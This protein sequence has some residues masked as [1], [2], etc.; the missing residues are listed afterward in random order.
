MGWAQMVKG[1]ANAANENL[2]GGLKAADAYYTQ[3][4]NGIN[5]G[6]QAAVLN[7]QAETMDYLSGQAMERA[8][9]A[10]EAGEQTA[11]RRARQASEDI[12]SA[13]AHAAGAGFLVGK[14]TA[15]SVEENIRAGAAEDIET[16]NRNT[17][18]D[19]WGHTQEAANLKAQGILTRGDAEVARI[20]KKL[21]KKLGTLGAIYEVANGVHRGGMAFLNSF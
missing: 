10:Q 7:T 19:V 8:G 1:I 16:I 17:W 15:K 9:L 5:Y 20:N 3:R 11:E 21:S 13:R 2:Q 18:M 6:A 14:G 4:I 12:G